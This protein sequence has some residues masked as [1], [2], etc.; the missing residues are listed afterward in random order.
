M[1]QEELL[2]IANGST[3]QHSHYGKQ[4]A[5]YCKLRA[6]DLAIPRIANGNATVSQEPCLRVVTAAVFLMARNNPMAGELINASRYL[7]NGNI[8]QQCKSTNHKSK[9]LDR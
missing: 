9:Q 2:Y 7:Q 8:L 3:D 1:D 6:Y 5:T 4:L